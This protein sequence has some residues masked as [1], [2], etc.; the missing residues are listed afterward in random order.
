MPTAYQ[1]AG[2]VHYVS[3]TGHTA[4]GLAAYFSWPGFFALIAFLTGGA[5]TEGLATLLKVWPTMI[6]LLCL[7]PLF[8]LMRNLRISWRAQWL[9]AFFF[10]VGNW[11]GQDYFSP[12]SFAFLL[13][14]VFVAILVNWFVDL[15]RSQ[16]RL[17]RK[18]QEALPYRRSSSSPLSPGELS[19]RPAGSGQ[20]AFLLVLLV[21]IFTVATVSHQLTPFFMIGACAGLVV[22]RRCTLSGLPILLGVILVGYFSFA[23]VG[24]WSGHISNVFS[25]VGHLG[26]NLSTGVSG[27][28]AGSTPTHLL[29]LHAR[30]A[31]PVAIIGLAGLGWLQ[32]RGRGTSD[33]VLLVLLVVPVAPDRSGEL[34]RGDHAP[35]LPV[36]VAG[37]V[38]A[39]RP[40]LLSGL[41][42]RPVRTG[43]PWRSLAACAV[44][45]PVAFVLARYGN[46]AFEQVPPGELAASNWVYAHDSHGVRL[47]WLSTD[48]ANDVTPQMPWAYRDL[49]KVLY[50]P[51]LAPR[52]PA[53]VEG[54]RDFAGRR[55]ARVIP[56]R[57]PDPDSGK[58]NRPPVTLP[59]GGPASGH[60]WVRTRTC[61]WSTPTTVPSSTR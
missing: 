41:A 19:P 53:S 50:V 44:V 52:D 35:D 27:R 28:L 1:I 5:G 37:R 31:V 51:A 11:V 17:L 54:S 38:R 26:L 60:R 39:R 34:R 48:P 6:D 10:V 61:G 32:R 56:D 33:R 59:T 25:G 58:R 36:H 45:L 22:V 21:A 49:T 29:A 55:R 47:L 20:K 8:L 13:Y 14:L 3:T 2:L 30:V 23:T 9:A 16:P 12:Q 7:V 42:S 43:A 15:D 46:E 4:P 57:R 40:G 24:Y 18:W